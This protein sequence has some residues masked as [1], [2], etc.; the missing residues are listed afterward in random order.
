MDVE[1]ADQTE[2]RGNGIGDQRAVHVRGVIV[3]IDEIINL[4]AVACPP[5]VHQNLG[6]PRRLRVG[7]ME[8]NPGGLDRPEHRNCG[9]KGNDAEHPANLVFASRGV[10]KVNFGRRFQRR[11]HDKTLANGHGFARR[12]IVR[13][14]IILC[15]GGRADDGN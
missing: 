8:A 7:L 5:A 15:G 1:S 13:V 3:F 6:F 14:I 10:G 12:T 9:E 11:R 4:H 2:N